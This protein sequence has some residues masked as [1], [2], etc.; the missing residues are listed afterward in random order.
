MTMK[1]ITMPIAVALGISFLVLNEGSYRR[2]IGTIEVNEEVLAARIEIRRLQL[3]MLAAET[4][5]RGY[6]LTGNQ[7][8]LRP[9]LSSSAALEHQLAT[10][11]RVYGR[12]PDWMDELRDVQRLA[13]ARL[14]ELRTAVELHDRGQ[15][16][17]ALDLLH[18]GI[19]LEDLPC[20][21]RYQQ[22]LRSFPCRGPSC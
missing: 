18:T 15:A 9:F 14:A 16:D 8:F 10:L 6:L 13:R 11:D 17:A 4:G 7:E 22:I 5:Q 2:A 21:F 12:Q 3:L 20:A 1:W 19:G